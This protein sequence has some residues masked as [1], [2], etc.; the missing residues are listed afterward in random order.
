VADLRFSV[1]VPLYN[2]RGQI[3]RTLTSAL[4]QTHP[5]DEIIV[6]NDAS[7]DGGDVLVREEFGDRVRVID[8]AHGGVARA[9]NLGLRA[10]RNEFV[11][12][13]DGDDEWEPSYLAEIARLIRAFPTAQ[14]FS[15][16]FWVYDHGRRS[17]IDDGVAPDFFGELSFF[18][19]YRRAFG[20]VSSS[21]VCV[22]KRSFD[23][24]IVLPEGAAHGEDIYYWFRL[25]MLGPMAFSATRLVNIHRDET[26]E[27]FRR[28]IGEVP[29]YVRW[30]ITQLDTIPNANDRKHVRRILRDHSLKTG[31]LA[32]QLGQPEYLRQ[33][34]AVLR[35]R[36]RPL[37]T[38]VSLLRLVPAWSIR[39]LR[40]ARR[41]RAAP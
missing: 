41:K 12:L 24:G 16:G 39:L 32:V 2:K 9:R 19:A 5:A 35:E 22:R 28:R 26:T 3:A 29:Y 40:R 23:E 25:A 10:A 31:L 17:T 20:I 21:S 1:V 18:A 14:F 34:H 36:N 11:C 6:V 13:L 27:S 37:A 7:T 4:R 15:V 38:A 33:L 8:A 30:G